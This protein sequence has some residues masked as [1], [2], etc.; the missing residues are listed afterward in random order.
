MF[1]DT[2]KMTGR[3]T[4]KRFGQNGDLLEERDIPNLVVTAGKTHIASKLVGYTGSSANVLTHMAVGTSAT[5]SA[6][7]NTT[8]G[9][10][11]ARSAFSSSP[12]VSSTTV[13][14][15]ASFTGLTANITEAGIFNAASNGTMLCRT[16]FA[17]IPAVST[18]TIVI[19]WNVS[20]G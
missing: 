9:A 3:L 7:A 18:D 5:A 4:V 19:S 1:N 16:T 20:V 8:L 12:T 11:I 10:E 2:I 13:T 15:S 6:V 17:L 14:Y